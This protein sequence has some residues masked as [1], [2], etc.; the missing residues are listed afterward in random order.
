MPSRLDVADSQQEGNLFF[1]TLGERGR[2]LNYSQKVECFLCSIFVFW[3]HSLSLKLP[4]L[5]ITLKRW[6]E[7]IKHNIMSKCLIICLFPLLLSKHPWP[8]YATGPFRVCDGTCL[9]YGSSTSFN[10]WK[11][12]DWFWPTCSAHLTDAQLDWNPENVE[13]KSTPQTPPAA[14]VILVFLH[15]ILHQRRQSRA[16]GA[17]WDGKAAQSS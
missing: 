15:H 12:V 8:I 14:K 3:N 1:R 17:C 16:R 4:K 6:R 9:L 11:M 10:S 2:I 7:L 13:N 5:V